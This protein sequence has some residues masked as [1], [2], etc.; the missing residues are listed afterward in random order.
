MATFSFDIEGMSCGHCVRAVEN[1]LSEVAGVRGAEV[2]VGHADVD[3][4]EGTSRDALVSAIEE[5]GYQVV[6]G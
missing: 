6:G 4:E 1:A 5:E 2:R 3:A